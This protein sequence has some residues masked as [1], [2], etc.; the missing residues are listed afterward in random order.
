MAVFLS[1]L[2]CAFTCKKRCLLVCYI[3]EMERGRRGQGERKSGREG[4]RDGGVRKGGRR[5][6]EES[7]RGTPLCWAVYKEECRKQ[8]LGSCSDG[9]EWVG[10]ALVEESGQSKVKVIAE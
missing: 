7:R 2:A 5:G 8:L 9:G 10:E 3:E 4:G 1:L 6:E